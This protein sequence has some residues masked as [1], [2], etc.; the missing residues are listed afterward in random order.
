PGKFLT[1]SGD[2][3]KLVDIEAERGRRVAVDMFFRTLADTHGPHATA[4][5]LSGADGD[6]ALGLKRIKEQG[7]L[8]I[9]QEPSEAEQA[10]MPQSAIDTGMVDWVLPVEEIPSRLLAYRRTESLLRLPPEVGPDI[11]AV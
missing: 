4:I 1:T 3:L 5:V 11:P 2:R 6:G 10:G 9:S 8:T 7:G